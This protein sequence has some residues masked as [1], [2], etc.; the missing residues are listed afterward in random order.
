MGKLDKR[1]HIPE[2]VLVRKYLRALGSDYAGLRRLLDV[3]EH[4][5]PTIIDGAFRTPLT[6]LRA[7]EHANRWSQSG[8]LPGATLWG[9]TLE[10][11]NLAKVWAEDG[12]WP[13]YPEDKSEKPVSKSSRRR[14]KRRQ[15][16]HQPQFRV[17]KRQRV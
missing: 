12:I 15:G 14:G 1:H 4:F 11:V 3:P 13:S 16:A 2:A 5:T 6:L 8:V 10:P 7:I 17:G 9:E